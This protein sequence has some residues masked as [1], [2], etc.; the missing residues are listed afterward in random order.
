LAAAS[1]AAFT[2]VVV[3]QMANAFACRSATRSPRALGGFSNPLLVVVVG[4]ELLALGA[5]LLTG[6]IADLLDHA[7]P[8]FAGLAVAMAAAPAVLIADA[9]HKRARHRRVV[10]VGA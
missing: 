4:V 9:L 7:A 8:S 1:G 10:P 2:A 5:F 3:G 6:P